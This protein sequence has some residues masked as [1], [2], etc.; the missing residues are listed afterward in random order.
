MNKLLFTASILLT[1]VEGCR[2]YHH[3]DNG[4]SD[5]SDSTSNYQAS[6]KPLAASGLESPIFKNKVDTTE[7]V[8]AEVATTENSIDEET[9][10][11]SAVPQPDKLLEFKSVAKYLKRLGYQGSIR[12]L[13][14]EKDFD[15]ANS[16]NFRRTVGDKSCTVLW[17]EGQHSESGQYGYIVKVE[18]EG[19]LQALLDFYD[20]AQNLRS[21]T[22]L[23]NLEINKSGFVVTIQNLQS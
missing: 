9:Q 8:Q 18:I 7:S 13:S 16:G 5:S 6:K 11:A 3:A 21:D 10:F 23:Q 22:Q 1:L 2:G 15:N 17:S 12:K 14:N 4:N 20:K 19:D